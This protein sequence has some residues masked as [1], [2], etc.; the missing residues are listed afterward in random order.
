MTA[1]TK[2]ICILTVGEEQIPYEFERKRI[3]RLNLRVRQDGTVHLSVPM[4]TPTAFIES[5]LRER[6]LWIAEARARMLKSAPKETTLN[7]G[8]TLLIGGAPHTVQI[9]EGARTSCTCRDGVLL[10]TLPDAADEAAK[11][12]ALRRFV[13][14][15]SA[16]YLTARMRTLWADF[17]P[18]PATF[19]T[20]SF[21]WMKSRWGS[22]TAAKITSR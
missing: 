6:A 15:E 8:D 19:P 10:L 20:L 1:A 16:L 9:C 17:S 12:R 21:R 14:R 18:R 2:K 3:K 13:K 7:T 11:R 4:T 5:F 22:C